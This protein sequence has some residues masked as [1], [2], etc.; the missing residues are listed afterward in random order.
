VKRIGR[1][2]QLFEQQADRGRIAA[3][4]D[5]L[6]TEEHLADRV[7]VTLHREVLVNGPDKLREAIVDADDFLTFDHVGKR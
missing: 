6:A 4:H 5:L 1:V 2:A 7:H 3:L